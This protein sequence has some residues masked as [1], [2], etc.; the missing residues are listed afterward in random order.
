MSKPTRKSVS[1]RNQ[2]E[3]SA[4]RPS[5]SPSTRW[6]DSVD[7]GSSC[8]SIRID[9][10]RLMDSHTRRAEVIAQYR[11]LVMNR[12]SQN[13]QGEPTVCDEER[14]DWLREDEW[15]RLFSLEEE[16]CSC[17]NGEQEPP[18]REE[19]E[20]ILKQ[21]EEVEEDREL[22][23]KEE[24]ED[25]KRKQRE[26]EE[27]KRKQREEEEEDRKRK[28]REEEEDRKRKQR[29]EEERKRKQKEEE[30]EW[31]RRQREEDK[32][33][34][35][36][37]DEVELKVQVEQEEERMLRLTEEVK[38]ELHLKE[39]MDLQLR[40]QQE[41]GQEPELRGEEEHNRQSQSA[42]PRRTMSAESD[43]RSVSPRTTAT[44]RAS[45]QLASGAAVMSSLRS[46]SPSSWRASHGGISMLPM[47]VVAMKK[48]SEQHPLESSRRR[49]G[50]NSGSTRVRQSLVYPLVSP[51]TATLSPVTNPSARANS[52]SEKHPGDTPDSVISTSKQS[53]A[54]NSKVAVREENNVE[55]PAA[56][57]SVSSS[58][59]KRAPTPTSV[60]KS[61]TK[62]SGTMSSETKSST[63]R[64][65]HGGKEQSELQPRSQQ[66][67]K[68]RQQAIRE[69][70]DPSLLTSATAHTIKVSTPSREGPRSQAVA[71][72]AVDGACHSIS[73]ESS[74]RQSEWAP[75]LPTTVHE[76]APQAKSR[77]G[78]MGSEAP[79]V[80]PEDAFHASKFDT[81]TVSTNLSSVLPARAPA[82]STMEE[83]LLLL[84]RESQKGVSSS[85]EPSV[86]V[87]PTRRST[88]FGTQTNRGSCIASAAAV[89]QGMLRRSREVVPCYYCGEMQPL[90]TYS[91]HL[92]FC[93]TKTTA[94]Y[95]RYGLSTLRL[96]MGIPTRCIPEAV[97]EATREELDAFTRACYECVK[98]SI[99]P[100]P[101]CGTHMRVHDLPEHAEACKSGANSGRRTTVSSKS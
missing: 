9:Y 82:G 63:K 28:Q 53:T 99:I 80:D 68:Q 35:R 85:T 86:R 21:K 6:N 13:G 64:S 101:G 81:R 94:L 24:E 8:S 10:Q 72:D 96:N 67:I 90:K 3:S 22:R 1:E 79:R 66:N 91:L 74:S 89:L 83:E 36:P 30:E 62:R 20:V 65:T 49:E 14:S 27:R 75:R 58:T 39:E 57:A 40:L 54:H 73:N 33:R 88:V 37:K 77:D 84:L 23:A 4:L 61:S 41:E 93:R 78:K 17:I 55:K 38:R 25:R 18:L 59:H 51:T 100:C 16:R 44:S 26:E 52:R 71:A 95:R 2:S 19:G 76:P 56:K 60:A 31:K 12:R 45:A 92:D 32:R 87:S 69:V 47:S 43:N 70:E 29:E 97:S 5:I 15:D 50:E 34:N 46:S 98:V 48:P 7:R 42:V 11:Q